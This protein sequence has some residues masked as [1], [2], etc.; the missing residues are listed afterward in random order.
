M[1]KKKKDIGGQA[2]I[3][4]VMMK[5]K[6][7]VAVAVRKPNQKIHVKVSRYSPLTK[8]SIILRIPI[9]RGFTELVDMLVIGIK[10]L[11]YS[12]DIS[13]G[14]EE[15]LTKGEVALTF[16]VAI[17]FTIGLFVALPLFIAKL[18]TKGTGFWFDLVDGVLR[19]AIF[20]VYVYIISRM[21]DMRAV[22]QYHGAEHCAVHCYESGK[23]LTPE[24]A[25]KYTTLHP[26]CGTS[27]LVIVIA[28]SIVVFSFITDPRWYVKFISR[29]VLIPIIAGIGYELLKLSAKY[30]KSFFVRIITKPGL[31]VQRLT[32]LRPTK[33]QVEVAIAALNKVK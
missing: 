28:I 26:R 3:E 23:K 6:T 4:G 14:E 29:V 22:F 19:L 13:A 21:K 32:T 5:S 18:F 20:L 24:N 8:R 31:W 25:V 10:A 12:A 7:R 11:T 33:K 27:F 17:I 2:V 9:I 1:E 30:E 15:K 16:L